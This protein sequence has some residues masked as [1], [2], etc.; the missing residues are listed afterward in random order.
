MNL[1]KTVLKRPVTTVMV[2]LCLIVFGLT[3]V[4]SSKL[5]LIPSMDMPM[6]IV[7]ATYPGASPDDVDQLVVQPIEDETGTL[8]GIKGVTSVSNENYGIVL[9][10]YD[11]GTDIDSAYDDLKKKMDAI[12]LPDDVKTPTIMEMNINDVA[13]I[14][15][16]VNNDAQNDLYNYVNDEVVPEFVFRG[17]RGYFRWSEGVCKDRASSGKVKS[18]SFVH[19][20]HH[21]SSKISGFFLSGGKHPGGKAGAVC[22]SRCGLQHHGK[23]EKDPDHCGRQ[24]YHLLRGCCQYL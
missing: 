5:E 16:A 8:T 17:K 12:E 19:E 21:C 23:P 18:V 11:Y 4:F 9:L 1:T 14:T 20:R 3:S 24:Q 7:M 13:S 15:L 10:E 2:I 22:F 6:L